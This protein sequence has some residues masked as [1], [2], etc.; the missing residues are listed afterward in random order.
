MLVK[1]IANRWVVNLIGLMVFSSRGVSKVIFVYCVNVFC[2]IDLCIIVF[3]Y[4]N[5]MHNHY[6]RYSYPTSGIK[7]I[8][9]FKGTPLLLMVW[10]GRVYGKYLFSTRI[11]EHWSI[12]IIASSLRI[13][14]EKCNEFV[15]RFWSLK[16]RISL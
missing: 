12:V 8:I 7:D 14:I 10:I 9:R 15:F 5:H 11:L 2:A 3:D 4:M 13:E 1:R 16:W 6:K